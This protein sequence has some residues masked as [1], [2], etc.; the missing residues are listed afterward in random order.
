MSTELLNEPAFEPMQR[1]TKDLK[2][3]ARDL[4]RRHARYLVDTYYQ[5]Q[6]FRIRL[7]GQVRAAGE[8]AEPHSLLIWT[9]D[10]MHALETDLKS[11]LGEFAKTY[12]VGAWM[13]SICGIGPV[14]SAGLLSELD[15]RMA[16]TAGQFWRLAGLDPTQTWLGKAKAA[17]A[18][19]GILDGAK[20]PNETHLHEAAKLIPRHPENLRKQLKDG[21]L[22]NKTLVDAVA[23]RPWNASLKCL[24]AFK[25]GESFVKV[26]SRESDFYGAYYVARKAA[27]AEA[28]EA[29]RFKDQAEAA[30]QAKRYGK[31][32]SSY[33]CY[34]EGKLPP[35]Q[36]HARA[37][38][39]AV[40]LF[41]SH[42]HQ[43]MWEDYHGKPAS[44][45]PKPYAFSKLE[46]HRHYIDPPD[47]PGGHEGRS[48]RELYADG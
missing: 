25:L 41:L 22:T 3:A 1:L 34:S 28:N 46:G 19:Q 6:D 36:I 32:T 2:R 35:A 45:Y 18:V 38:R 27:E 37:R 20:S 16:P 47:W 43:V 12:R 11:C 29:G 17:E 24:C 40:K 23:R 21:K 48:L 15:I 13:Q 10:N 14:L 8:S 33:K 4:P 26:Q 42:L 44:E 9:Q 31:D 30:L 7:G 5:I 39:Y